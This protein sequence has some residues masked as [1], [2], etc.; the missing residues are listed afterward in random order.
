MESACHA[1]SQA[2]QSHFALEEIYTAAMDF[3]AKEAFTENFCR[4]TFGQ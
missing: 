3:P 4:Q 2:A 1:L